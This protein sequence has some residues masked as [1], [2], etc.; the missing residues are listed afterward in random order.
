MRYQPGR[1]LITVDHRGGALNLR[2]KGT[3]HVA[4]LVQDG[5][6]IDAALLAFQAGGLTNTTSDGWSVMV[7]FVEPGPYSL[8][9]VPAANRAAF[10][11]SNGAVGGR[12]T[13]GHLPPGGTLSLTLP[14]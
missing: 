8:C 5:A 4:T 10:R 11:L 2:G 7:P 6:I 14:E 3:A 9:S 1:F 13:S 12:C